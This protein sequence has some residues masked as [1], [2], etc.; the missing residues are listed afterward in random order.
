LELHL[1]E[2]PTTGYRWTLAD[3]G[4]PVCVLKEDEFKPESPKPGAGGIRT[5]TFTVRQTG[6][7]AISLRHQRKWGGADAAGE[8][9]VHVRA[10]A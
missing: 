8:F 3:T 7:S 10:T 5:L 6:E 9:T 2:N 4:T 1:K